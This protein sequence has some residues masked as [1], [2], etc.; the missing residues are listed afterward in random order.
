[1]IKQRGKTCEKDLPLFNN[2]ITNNL[3]PQKP[4]IYSSLIAGVAFY[5][6]YDEF[7]III[8]I[9]NRHNNGDKHNTKNNQTNQ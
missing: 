9:E 3:G 6:Q 8:I 2:D 7:F 1:M 4:A 5:R